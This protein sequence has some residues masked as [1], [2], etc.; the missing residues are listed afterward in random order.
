[1]FNS[2]EFDLKVVANRQTTSQKAQFTAA[3]GKDRLIA[4][5]N[6]TGTSS[7]EAVAMKCRRIECKLEKTRWVGFNTASFD[8][9]SGLGLA[10]FVRPIDQL[11]LVKD[12]Q[13]SFF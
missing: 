11:V 6:A 7:G 1:M 8:E 5:V 12:F 2:H 13:T 9:S 10:F 4:S 3:S